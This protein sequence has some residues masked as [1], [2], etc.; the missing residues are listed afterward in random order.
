MIML[1]YWCLALALIPLMAAAVV[2]AIRL[3]GREL[4]RAFGAGPILPTRR[5]VVLLLAAD[6]VVVLIV[7]F[8]RPLFN[9]NFGV[10]DPGHVYRSARPKANL[11]WLL[12]G[13]HVASVLSLRDEAGGNRCWYAGEA[14]LT[15]ERGVLLFEIPLSPRQRPSRGELLALLDLMDR[16]RYPLL[17]HSERGADRSALAS[18]LYLMTRRGTSPEAALSEFSLFYG[19]IPVGGHEH[20]HEPFVEYARWL[21]HHGLEHSPGRL[22]SWIEQEYRSPSPVIAAN[23]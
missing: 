17:I 5:V 1:V 8:H 13:C 2:A 22:R 21:R 3:G 20:L 23:S 14:R 19:H 12:D 7:F 16:C 10:V 18:G 4:T 6:V 15:R 9:G 11:A